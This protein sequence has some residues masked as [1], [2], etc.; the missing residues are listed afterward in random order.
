MEGVKFDFLITSPPYWNMMR[1]GSKDQTSRKEYEIPREYGDSEKDIGNCEKY[2]QFM[3]EFW[4]IMNL[5]NGVLKEGAY[6]VVIVRD[7]RIGKRYTDFHHDIANILE[8]CGYLNKGVRILCHDNIPLRPF[9]LGSAFV[10]NVHHDYILIHQK[11]KDT[12]KIIA[13]SHLTE[14]VE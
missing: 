8:R 1:R 4:E 13:Q 6:V 7:F 11:D 10:P 2:H 9:G 3:F 5:C 14:V 12:Q